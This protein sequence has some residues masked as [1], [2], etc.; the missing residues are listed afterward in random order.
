MPWRRTAEAAAPSEVRGG[1]SGGREGRGG[2]GPAR[3]AWGRGAE[4]D[5]LRA[6]GR[7]PRRPGPQARARSPLGRSVPARIAL[8]TPPR[9]FS[10]P[11][12]E[13]TRAGGARA[14]SWGVRE[15]ARWRSATEAAAFRPCWLPAHVT[16]GH[17][18]ALE[19]LPSR[20]C[21]FVRRALI[22]NTGFSCSGAARKPG[23]TKLLSPLEMF[24]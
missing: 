17:G 21:T 1:P 16:H 18:L 14:G 2:R 10:R 19:G 15:A 12:T 7:G 22:R 5:P 9:A 3:Q 4:P 23:G 20:L 11:G 24:S 13:L 6:G 8:K